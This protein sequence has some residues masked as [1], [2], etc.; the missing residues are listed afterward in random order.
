MLFRARFRP[1]LVS[2]SALD[3]ECPPRPGGDVG[4]LEPSAPRPGPS[5]HGHC[6]PALP[7]PPAVGRAS[8]LAVFLWLQQRLPGWSLGRPQQAWG[9]PFTPVGPLMEVAQCWGAASA[10]KGRASEHREHVRTAS[11]GSLGTKLTWVW[12]PAT[13]LPAVEPGRP[14]SLRNLW[15]LS[16]ED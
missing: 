6:A 11:Y 14:A 12:V 8:Y 7:R 15:I 1:R 9:G 5:H 3:T 2:D 4:P 16:P 13:P 10:K